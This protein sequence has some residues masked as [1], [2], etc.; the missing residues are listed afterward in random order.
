MKKAFT[1]IELLVVIAIIAILAAIL[2]PVFAQAKLAAKR[3]ADLSNAKQVGIAFM[4]YVNDY[5]DTSP[6]VYKFKYPGYD[7][8]LTSAYGS[9]YN[10]L[11]PYIK[12]WDMLLSPGR[13]DQ[14]CKDDINPTGKCLGY[15]YNDGLVSDSGYGLLQ[16]QSVDAFGK[17]VRIGRNLSEIQEPANMVAFGGSNDSPGYSVALDNIFSDYT[18]HISSQSVRFNGRFNYGFA[19]GHA[20]LIVMRAAEYPGFSADLMAIPASATD[21]LKWCHDPNFVPDAQFASDNSFPPD[22]PLQ[23]GSETCAQ[24]VADIFAN[25]VVNP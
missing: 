11:E 24:A 15:G 20:K 18:D 4:M 12:S 13:N 14:G 17:T 25:A 7:G 10:E 22:Y 1:L 8:V 2:F 21:A 23:S 19:D 9:W 3:T 16:T 5:D 6:T